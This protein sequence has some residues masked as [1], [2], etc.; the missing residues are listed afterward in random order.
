MPHT[1]A[2]ASSAHKPPTARD[3]P[4]V[5]LTNITHVDASEFKPYLTQVEALYEQLRRVKESEDE[6]ADTLNRRSSKQDE[7]GDAVGDGHLRPRKAPATFEE[8]VG[9]V[10]IFIIV[11]R[12]PESFSEDE[13][14]LQQADQPRT[15]AAVY[16]TERVL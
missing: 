9:H 16:H 12:G 6:D 2:P 5:A 13:L 1:S 8:V 4:P 7:L 11:R 14:W 3:I 10:D 15:A